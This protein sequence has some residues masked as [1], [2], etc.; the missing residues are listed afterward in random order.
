MLGVGARFL[1]QETPKTSV[2]AEAI[3]EPQ[4]EFDSVAYPCAR[5]KSG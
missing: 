5:A 4:C 2:D 3:D 1:T